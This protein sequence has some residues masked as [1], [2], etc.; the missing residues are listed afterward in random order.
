MQITN[1]PGVKLIF[2]LIEPVI[3]PV[4]QNAPIV[5]SLFGFYSTAQKVSNCT[6]VGG[7]LKEATKGIFISCTPPVVRYPVLCAALLTTGT[8][9]IATGGHPLAI[10]CFV[11]TGN[12]IVDAD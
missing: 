9:C 12:L 5:G 1:L 7:V 8:A 6:S 4:K 2:P 11:N 10:S 3:E